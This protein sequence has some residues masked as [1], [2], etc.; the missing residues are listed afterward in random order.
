MARLGI[1]FGT[2]NTVAAIYDRGLASVVLHQAKTSSGT[3]I[4]EVFIDDPGRHE[5]G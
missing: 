2:T 3:I 4:Q 1:D 5:L